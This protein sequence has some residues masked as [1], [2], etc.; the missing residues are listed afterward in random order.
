MSIL[1]KLAAIS[2]IS[3]RL[4]SRDR[5]AL[6]FVVILPFLIILVVGSVTGADRP[7]RLGVVV[8]APG[9]RA[10]ALLAAL[11]ANE[12]LDVV[13]MNS[14]DIA[15]RGVRRG[16]LAGALVIPAGLD[17]KVA[18]GRSVQLELLAP[19]DRASSPAVR[20]AVGAIVQQQSGRLAAALAIGGAPSFPQRLAATE[21]AEA[22]L[23][24]P[25]LRVAQTGE[26]DGGEL[27][28]FSHTAPANLVLFVFVTSLASGAAMI[29]S[30]R[31]GILR[32]MLASPTSVST[33]L[34]GSAAARFAIALAQAA[35]ILLLG[36]FAFGVRWGDPLAAGLLIGVFAVV[37]VGAGL[38]ISTVF[39]TA[40]QAAAVA[41]PLGI[42]L[43]MLGG[44][45]WPLEIVGPLMRAVGHIT[46]HAW[47][48]DAWARLVEDGAGLAGIAR[49]LGV[50]AV[51][52]VVLF[53][54]GAY[55]LRADLVA[56]S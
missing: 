22:G 56:G 14:T 19:L 40:E 47:A 39:R 52:A 50:L 15:M 8:E 34:M 46:P 24:G 44:C 25:V 49:P 17:A 9:T 33:V 23:D 11:R 26:D 43:G 21:Q 30:R 51:Y 6:F 35:L 31:L 7:A 3:L 29:E 48:M 36:R 16:R 53:G 27:S 13:E 45:M 2:G 28:R 10:G 41:P 37:S 12:A 54:V 42:A 5:T 20:A 1:R 18:A 55:R 32:R 4:I 38:L